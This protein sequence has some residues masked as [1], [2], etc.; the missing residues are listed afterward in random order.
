MNRQTGQEISLSYLQEVDMY[1]FDRQFDPQNLQGWDIMFQ[2]VKISEALL[3]DLFILAQREDLLDLK[4]QDTMARYIKARRAQLRH[5][6]PFLEPHQQRRMTIARAR[7]VIQSIRSNTIDERQWIPTSWDPDH[8]QGLYERYVE[9]RAGGAALLNDLDQYY[10]KI[11]Q[12]QCWTPKKLSAY[13]YDPQTALPRDHIIYPVSRADFKDPQA[14]LRLKVP[15]A[16]LDHP[17]KDSRYG[18]YLFPVIF[19]KGVRVERIMSAMSRA[20]HI[21]FQGADTGKLYLAPHARGHIIALDTPANDNL[22]LR[23]R[24]VF[25]RGAGTLPELGHEPLVISAEGALPLAG[26]EIIK[27][28]TDMMIPQSQF[29]AMIAPAL[30]GHR[31]SKG[32]ISPLRGCAVLDYQYRSRRGYQLRKNDL[33]RLREIDAQQRETGWE[34]PVILNHKARSMTLADL[35]QAL[36]TGKLSRDFAIAHGFADTDTLLTI[37]TSWVTQFQKH[38]DDPSN[39]ILFLDFTRA[40][41]VRYFMPTKPPRAAVAETYYATRAALAPSL[42]NE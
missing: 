30:T 1:E 32:Q 34:I 14:T 3:V 36:H 9:A 27:P 35:T 7:Q 24:A 21:V 6:A 17:V 12:K 38:P 37:L 13:G 41:D 8:R 28:A 42:Q 33:V 39:K 10:K 18:P 5:G 25:N 16:A 40:G 11:E 19:E 26:T 4:H 15:D 29:L 31:D 2:Q 22:S 20:Q 23:L